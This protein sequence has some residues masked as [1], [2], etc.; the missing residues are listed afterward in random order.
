MSRAFVFSPLIMI[1]NLLVLANITNVAIIP[2]SYADECGYKSDGK[3]HCGTDCGYKSDGNYHCGADCGYKS[4]GN[5]HCS[6]D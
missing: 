1:L 5:Y 2:V 3:Y 4:D 6:G